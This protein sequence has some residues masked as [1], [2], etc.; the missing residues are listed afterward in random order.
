M[1]FLLST[2]AD[3]VFNQV[4]KAEMTSKP[5]L[6]LSIIDLFKWPVILCVSSKKRTNYCNVIIIH[7]VTIIARRCEL[8]EAILLRLNTIY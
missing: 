2:A 6:M 4:K 5:Y 8:L 3:I 1:V 7:H